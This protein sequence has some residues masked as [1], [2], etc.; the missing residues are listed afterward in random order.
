MKQLAFLSLS[1]I[2]YLFPNPLKKYII[3]F[4]ALEIIIYIFLKGCTI[5]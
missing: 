1:N 2:V 4:K 3:H 5:S